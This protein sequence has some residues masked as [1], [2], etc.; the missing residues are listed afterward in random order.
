VPAL[1]LVAAG[2]ARRDEGLLQG[3]AEGEYVL[4]ASPYAGQLERLRVRRGEQAQQ[5]QPLFA[6]DAAVERATLDAAVGRVEKSRAS[7]EDARKGQRPSE[8]AS[9]EAQLAQAQAAERNSSAEL[10]RVEPLVPSGALTRQ[11][12]DRAR[13]THDQDLQRVKQLE[14]DLQTARLGSREDLVAAAEADLRAQQAVQARAAWDVAQ[15]SQSA[16]A[17]A[18]VFDTLYREGEWVEAG[19]P[20]V[21][22]LPPANIKVRA[23]VPEPRIGAVRIGD[24]I[25]VIVDGVAETL[26]GTV[27]YVSPQAEYTPPVIYSRE[28]RDKLVFMIEARFEPEVAVKLHP[29]QPVDVRILG[30]R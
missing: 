15:K 5:G 8:I 19:K 30:P 22:L 11:D 29:G 26:A 6:L 20:V 1:A 12:L 2:C 3:Y 28:S 7:L 14:A 13:S 21:A 4:V 25:E 16:P 10:R 18:L 27:S 23:F 9:L 24:R 17:Q